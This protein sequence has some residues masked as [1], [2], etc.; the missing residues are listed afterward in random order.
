MSDNINCHGGNILNKTLLE[1]KGSKKH[2]PKYISGT[3][4]PTGP[5]GP[6]GPT[7]PTGPIGVGV[8]IKGSYDTLDDLENIHPVGNPDDAYVAGDDLYV[9][10]DD[11]NTWIDIGTI[12]GPQGEQGPQG[13][14]GSQGIQGPMG[15]T[16]PQGVPGEQGEQ[17]PPGP[18]G[19]QGIPGDTG[20]TGPAGTS[21][22]ILG[23][24][25]DLSEL[26]DAHPK[27]NPGD[28]YLVGSDLY[29]WSNEDGNWKNVGV[30]R[31]PQGPQGPKGEQGEQGEQG[32]PG[33]Q[34]ERGIQGVQGEQGIPGPQG[35][36]GI[37][38][39]QGIYEIKAAY[40]TTYNNNFPSGYTVSSNQRLPLSAKTYD[41]AELCTLNTNENTISF[42]EEGVYKIDFVVSTYHSNI[43]S[44]SNI[45]AVGFKKVGEPTVYAG[46]SLWYGESVSSPIV[47]QGLFVIGSAGE[48]MELVNLS[49]SDL[50]LNT[51]LIDETTSDSYLVNP[52]VTIT[53]QYL[54]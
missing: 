34:G 53:I 12:K 26:K 27:G 25:D 11:E 1:L 7:G 6:T 8:T 9:W 40:I 16:G 2:C 19:P 5:I 15:S 54:G 30:I 22:T 10:S 31:G 48:K 50:T 21:V 44:L 14:Q 17:G 47:G 49:K 3:T 28:S 36:Q 41:N 4:G 18:Q 45:A 35:P 20:A 43:V 51:P 38:G 42:N 29:V 13:I 23:S 33:P 39:P 24:Y 46:G 32:I 37:P 52:L